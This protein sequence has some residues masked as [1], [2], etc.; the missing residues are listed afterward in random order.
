MLI[1]ALAGL[2]ISVG[3]LYLVEKRVS[4]RPEWS[5]HVTAV[6]DELPSEDEIGC[7]IS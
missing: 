2:G 1:G 4:G 6:Y 3:I 7:N 5:P